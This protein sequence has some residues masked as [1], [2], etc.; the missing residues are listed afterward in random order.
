MIVLEMIMIDGLIFKKILNW[1]SSMIWL[2]SMMELIKMK[3]PVYL[4]QLLFPFSLG[5]MQFSCMCLKILNIF[6]SMFQACTIW[7]WICLSVYN[8][9]QLKA[10]LIVKLKGYLFLLRKKYNKLLILQ[11]IQKNNLK[12]YSKR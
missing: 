3:H 6:S 5:G 9:I 12:K 4:Y 8:R 11:K 10:F 2:K 1:N 7:L